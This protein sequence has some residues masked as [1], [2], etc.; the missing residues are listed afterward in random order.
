M[1]QLVTIRTVSELIPIKGAD[2][3]ELAK[4]DGWQCVVKKGDFEVGQ[5]GFYFEIDSILPAD[6]ERFAFLEPRKFRIKSMKLRGALSQGLLMPMSILTD[7]EAEDL[8]MLA[9]IGSTTSTTDLAAFFRVQKYEP[10]MPIQGEQKGTFPT[11]L[12]P[13][14]VRRDASRSLS[15]VSFASRA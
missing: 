12:V 2:R 5:M 10:P 8:A 4:V 13:K 11:H 7:E 9:P 3:I 14:T 15:H 6:D 1:R